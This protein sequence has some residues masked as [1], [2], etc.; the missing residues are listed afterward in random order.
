MWLTAGNPSDMPPPLHAGAERRDEVIGSKKIFTFRG[1]V[2]SCRG[3]RM[4][5]SVGFRSSLIIPL[6]CL[7]GPV[8]ALAASFSLNPTLDAFVTT[9]PSGNLAGNNYGGAGA[10]SV[11]A[12][13]LS[14]GEFQS[15]LQFNLASAKSSFDS[16]FGAGLWTIQS[17]TLQLTAAGPNNAIFNSSSSGQFRLSW[18]QNDSWTEGT[19]TPAAPTTTGITFSTLSNFVSVADETLGTFSFNGATNGG[20]SYSLNLTPSFSADILSG[21]TL[22]MRMFAADNAVSYLSDSRS[23]GTASARPLLTITAVPEPGAAALGILFIAGLACRQ[24]SRRDTRR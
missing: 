14:Q 7:V 11:A 8:A 3:Y 6:F 22:S 18:M 15:V 4:K 23:F 20:F 13:G 12:A 19:G 2:I 21:S 17:V 1:S 16:Q 5:S 10:L 9:G 24:W